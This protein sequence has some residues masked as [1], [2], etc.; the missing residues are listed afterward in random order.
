GQGALVTLVCNVLVCA[1]PK[2]LSGDVGSIRGT[3]Q[4]LASA[5]GTAVMGAMLVTVLSTGRLSDVG[6]RPELPEKL[7]A[8]VDLDNTNIIGND[9]LRDVLADTTAT[10]EQIDHAVELNSEQ[11]LRTLKLGFLVLAGISLAA[12]LPA[13]RLPKYRPDEIPDPAEGADP[14][15]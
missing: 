8:Q 13:S 11:R 7:V 5:V 15:Q 6:V 10:P 3:A 4:N 14:G 2:H 9:G 1:A 12:A